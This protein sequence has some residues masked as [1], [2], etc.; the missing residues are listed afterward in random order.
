MLEAIA[1]TGMAPTAASR[2]LAIV[3]TA[4]YDA[5]APYDDYAVA[6]QSGGPPRQHPSQR[7]L[8]NKQK[9]T[10][11][12][13]YRTLTDLF[14]SQTARFDTLM[15]LLSYHPADTSL[16]PLAP[17]GVGNISAAALI[18][19]R[20][21]D[22]ANQLGT[23]PGSSGLP[24]SDYTG[25]TPINSPDVINDPKRWQPLRVP[26]VVGGPP[27][28]VQKPLAPHWGRVLPFAL[29]SGSQFRPG[30]PA[31]YPS[32]AYRRQIDE[33][34]TISA[35]LSDRQKVIAEYWAD[36]PR[37]STPPGHWCL[38][39]QEISH[40]DRHTL[41]KDVK[42]FFALGNALMDAG[43]AVWEAKYHFDYV[44]PVTAVRFLY[45]DLPIPAWGGPFQGTQIIMGRD[46]QPYRPLT[47]VTPPFSEYTSGHSAFSAA[48]AQILKSFTGSDVF[49]GSV[50]IPAGSST[51]EPGLV[52][53]ASV[54]LSWVTFLEAADEAGISRLYGGI[55]FK[56][57]D[58]ASRVMGRKIGK[59]VWEKARSYFKGGSYKT[60]E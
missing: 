8:A 55:H 16:D 2:A 35:Q 19:V 45:K 33:V 7:T 11:F 5:W 23:T 21:G 58:L 30:P 40:R 41:D 10:S 60:P 47:E 48:G 36:G 57:G 4:M 51:I 9:A 6:T 42:L 3:H 28:V 59:Q 43:I 12:A 24:Y 26:V 1:V 56:D 27:V 37:S 49:G 14:P 20:H 32:D 53:A 54:T 22:G 39:A 29:S 46:W 52:P 13:A 25:Y 34:I 15:A 31:P 50:V 44:R 17:T 38:F 18:S